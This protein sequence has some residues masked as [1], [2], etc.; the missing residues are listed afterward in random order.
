MPR[1]AARAALL[2]GDTELITSLSDTCVRES[3]DRLHGPGLV[4]YALRLAHVGHHVT[5]AGTQR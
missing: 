2:Y 5:I 4:R 1:T 3:A